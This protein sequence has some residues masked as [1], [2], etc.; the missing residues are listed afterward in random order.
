MKCCLTIAMLLLPPFVGASVAG[1]RSSAAPGKLSAPVV[2]KELVL[3]LATKDGVAAVVFGE[4]IEDGV[5]YH[6]RF[7]PNGTEK[8]QTGDG[9]VFEKYELIPTRGPHGLL[10]TGAVDKGGQLLIT[11]GPIK[12]E[13][14]YAGKGRGWVYYQPEDVRVQIAGAK[15]FK[16]YDLKRF[17]K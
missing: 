11:A 4:D 1:K 9:K 5:V 8:E 14:S 10:V 17:A 12:L 3:I 7:L 16:K 13:W 2:Y 15:D 6:Y